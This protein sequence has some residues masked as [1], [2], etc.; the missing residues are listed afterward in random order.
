MGFEQFKSTVILQLFHV[1]SRF[2]VYL[3]I[4]VKSL[5]WGGNP[6]YLLTHIYTH[7]LHKTVMHY[8]VF[9]LIYC[10]YSNLLKST[11]VQD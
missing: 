9:G 1:N 11:K 6:I 7:Y 5:G 8:F 10:H 2:V 3:Q 4:P